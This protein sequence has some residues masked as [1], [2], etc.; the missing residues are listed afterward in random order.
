[1]TTRPIF[2]RA[3]AA[4]SVALL[5]TFSSISSAKAETWTVVTGAQATSPETIA[6]SNIQK[7]LAEASETVRV[8]SEPAAVA[9]LPREG[10]IVLV[11][12]PESNRILKALM[13]EELLRIPEGSPD[14]YF[15]K[16]VA[17]KAGTPIILLTSGKPIGVI[18]AANDLLDNLK[19]LSH[20][21]IS[22][23][24]PLPYRGVEIWKD[25]ADGA[26]WKGFY[27]RNWASFKFP[28]PFEDYID[29]LL[30]DRIN[31]LEVGPYYFRPMSYVDY[32]RTPYPEAQQFP[33][34]KVTLW[35][36]TIQKHLKYAHDR[37]FKIIFHTY[38]HC[39]PASFYKAH[40]EIFNP[41][42]RYTTNLDSRGGLTTG[43]V[44]YNA[45]QN[46]S[47]NNALYKRFWTDSQRE[48]LKTLPG[49]DGFFATYGEWTKSYEG[50]PHVDNVIDYI[51][52]NRKLLKD[53][54]GDDGLL[55][56]RD[57]YIK[58]DEWLDPRMPRTI[59]VN[60][61]SG[62]DMGPVE[63]APWSQ[64]YIKAGHTVVYQEMVQH[65]ENTDPIL[66]AD[67]DFNGLRME[68]LKKS[69][70]KGVIL[71]G[72]PGE[73]IEEL[74]FNACVAA[75]WDGRHFTEADALA[76]LRRWYG[77]AAP[78]VYA[79]MKKACFAMSEYTKI[80][81]GRYAWWQSDGIGIQSV[82]TGFRGVATYLDPL[83][84]IRRNAVGV[85]DYVNYLMSDDGKKAELEA[86]WK[87]QG[88]LTPDAILASINEAA[89]DAEKEIFIAR[90]LAPDSPY[91][92]ELVASC[93]MLKY[94]A[95]QYRYYVEAAYDY[96]I[97]EKR[98][99]APDRKRHIKASLEKAA[100][101][102]EPVY[103]LSQIFFPGE[104]EDRFHSKD[105]DY[106]R[107]CA[108]VGVTYDKEI[109]L[110][111]DLFAREM[112]RVLFDSEDKAS[113]LK[114]FRRPLWQIGRIDG[115]SLLAEMDDASQKLWQGSKKPAVVEFKVGTS[116]PLSFP[117]EMSPKAVRSVAV[118]FEGALL[119][120]GLLRIALLPESTAGLPASAR[121]LLSVLLDGK[122][123]ETIKSP[124][125]FH[126]SEQRVLSYIFLPPS[127]GK[128]HQLKLEWVGQRLGAVDGIELL[129]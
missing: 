103:Y 97:L 38:E 71:H 52:T 48:L 83:D 12:T 29:L 75:L 15:V 47:W 37:G 45:V 69:G 42:G 35:R 123:L 58:V 65:A 18:Y 21:D 114:Q 13:E 6:A 119:A 91:M 96:F 26:T 84:Y 74:N 87:Q 72:V 32:K 25:F 88:L 68:N 27:P 85:P 28:L 3:A 62:F 100:E 53:E 122:K 57:W 9:D 99:D 90:R 16:T 54:R 111:E 2:E 10:K 49:L 19:D 66:W 67:V 14:N 17:R 70:A 64:D 51:N 1:M 120:G 24:T 117:P 31:L 79:A 50:V 33:D 92:T 40:E 118:N 43:P 124:I 98:P 8:M 112:S 129:N 41:N 73:P 63:P 107:E 128:Q 76:S 94:V 115:M 36:E 109:K 108:K 126:G 46:M 11:G 82:T 104:I 20:L 93:V 80:A 61:F 44:A 5:L 4:T 101:V 121:E 22:M 34:D 56:V 86:A 39:A 23:R 106:R 89:L 116:D 81:S 95:Q 125:F 60:K 7:G 127:T 105:K 113:L 110:D 77:D 30:K 78:H 59:I 102:W 55:M